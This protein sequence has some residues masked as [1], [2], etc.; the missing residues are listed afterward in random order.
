ME[1]LV[2]HGSKRNNKGKEVKRKGVTL[3]QKSKSNW[4]NTR[5]WKEEREV[6]TYISLSPSNTTCIHSLFHS[7]G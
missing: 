2:R 5:K 6:V 3:Q 4:K 1:E 7:N